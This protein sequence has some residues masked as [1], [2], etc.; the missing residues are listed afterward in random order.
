MLEV[1]G[2]VPVVLLRVEDRSN[3]FLQNEV[4]ERLVRHGLGPEQS[5]DTV[6]CLLLDIAFVPLEKLELHAN[7]LRLDLH[8]VEVKPVQQFLW[9]LHLHVFFRGRCVT[10]EVLGL[11]H[12]NEALH[13]RVVHDV[14]DDF[15]HFAGKLAVQPDVGV[16]LVQ[17]V[18][19]V[20]GDVLHSV[21]LAAAGR[22][23]GACDLRAEHLDREVL[24]LL[25]GSRSDLLYIIR[26]A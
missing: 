16:D 19:I 2:D 3:A 23:D 13:Y 14:A 18:H 24:Y 5:F 11:S 9:G 6:L 15:E 21:A 17:V 26:V 4:G 8:Y 7:D 20:V 1:D 10:L 22:G 12:L 25:A